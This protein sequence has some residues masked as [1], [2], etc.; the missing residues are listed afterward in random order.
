[1]FDAKPWATWF[2][3][4]CSDDLQ[5]IV[6]LAFLAPPACA[7]CLGP[8]GHSALDISRILLCSSRLCAPQLLF[9]A[10]L[11]RAPGLTDRAGTSNCFLSQICPVTL[12]GSVIDDTFIYSVNSCQPGSASI[13]NDQWTNFGPDLSPLQVTSFLFDAGRFRCFD[14]FVLNKIAPFSP[15]L[16]PTAYAMLFVSDEP[17]HRGLNHARYLVVD[18]A[19]VLQAISR[20][21]IQSFG[22]PNLPR[23]FVDEIQWISGKLYS[24]S[25]SPLD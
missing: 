11:L 4:N 7:S 15:P 24:T 18:K 17:R 12:L 22:M 9:G 20:R 8:R 25:T 21:S 3:R 6:L 10:L 14:F 2:D 1:M 23:V 16:I 19:T 13:P 5:A